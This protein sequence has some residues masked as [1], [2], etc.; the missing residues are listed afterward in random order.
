MG[1]EAFKLNMFIEAE[2][3]SFESNQLLLAITAS[4]SA[5]Y[6]INAGNLIVYNQD[7]DISKQDFINVQIGQTSITISPITLSPQFFFPHPFEG[8]SGIVFLTAETTPHFSAYTCSNNSLI[9]RFNDSRVISFLR[10]NP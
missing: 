9:I 4:G 6:T 3:S 2:G 5:N 7:Y 1:A 10:R 8:T